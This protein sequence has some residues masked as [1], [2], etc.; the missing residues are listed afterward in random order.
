MANAIAFDVREK[1]RIKR[2]GHPVIGDIIYDNKGNPSTIPGS[3]KHVKAI[4]WYIEEFGISQISMNLTNINQTPIHVVFDEVSKK[5]EKRGARVTG[6]E[7]VGLIPLKPMLDWKVFLKQNRSVGIP[8]IDIISIAIESLGLNQVKNL[9]QK[10]YNRILFRA[11]FDDKKKI[12]ELKASEF[13]DEVA[14]NLLHLEA[15]LSRLM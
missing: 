8:E 2:K 11:L 15:D 10:E 5:A 12:I 1:G 4:G 3:L 7:I 13:S 6:S 9:F 14:E